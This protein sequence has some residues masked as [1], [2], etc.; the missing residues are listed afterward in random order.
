MVYEHFKKFSFSAEDPT[1]F[2]VGG[3]KVLQFLCA[4]VA[5]KFR[6]LYICGT[7]KYVYTTLTKLQKLVGFSSR[8]ID[9]IHSI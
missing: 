9:I 7:W 6:S 4:K 3:T 5:A 1:T 2:I 8:A